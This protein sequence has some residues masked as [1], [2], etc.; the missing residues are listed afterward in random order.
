MVKEKCPKCKAILR[1]NKVL[2]IKICSNHEC[3]TLIDIRKKGEIN[4]N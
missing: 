1:I 2:K 3:N 4:E